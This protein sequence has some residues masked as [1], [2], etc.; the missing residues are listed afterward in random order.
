MIDLF[1]EFD[2]RFETHMYKFWESNGK[3]HW[4][5][6]N[7]LC[8]ALFLDLYTREPLSCQVA[9][10]TTRLLCLRNVQVPYWFDFYIFRLELCGLY[11]SFES[12][13]CY[14]KI[15]LF[16]KMNSLWF[17]NITGILNNITYTR[18]QFLGN[19][20]LYDIHAL[21]WKFAWY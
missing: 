9:T 7:L 12:I 11:S 4:L 13:A 5:Q 10:D 14:W 19:I 3:T 18:F 20:Q 8:T 16:S 2:C 17:P 21:I 1:K 15:L 6:I